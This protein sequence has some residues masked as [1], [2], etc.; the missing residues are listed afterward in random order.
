MSLDPDLAALADEPFV[1]LTT[2]RKTGAPVDTAVWVGRVQGALVVSTP[3]GTGKLK[4]L[5]HTPRVR[6]QPC[7]RR[8]TPRPG[9]AVVDARAQVTRDPAVRRDVEAALSAKYGWEWK[10]A[11]FVEKVVRRGRSMGRP[12]LLITS[13]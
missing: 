3:E 1:L 10:A 5:R 12:A 6:L 11:L 8:G 9:S 2:F 13:G 4:R 7:S